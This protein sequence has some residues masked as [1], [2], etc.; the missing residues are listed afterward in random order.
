MKFGFNRPSGF[1]GEDVF[2]ECGRKTTDDGGLPI[3]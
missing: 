3:L 2:K 1:G